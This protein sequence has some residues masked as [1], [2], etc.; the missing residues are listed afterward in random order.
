MS[1]P[2]GKITPVSTRSTPTMGR[3][4]VSSRMAVAVLCLI[5]FVDV[6]GVTVIVVALPSMLRDLD[7]AAAATGPVVTGY[8]MFFGGLLM[9]GARLGDRYGH[10]RVLVCGLAVFAVASLVGGVAGSVWLLVA[11]RCLQGCAAAVSVPT[12][13]R[14]LTWVTPSPPARRRAIAAWSAAGAAAG[15]SGFV[16]GGVATQTAGWRV[17]FLAGVPLAILLAV[18][19][20]RAVPETDDERADN[21]MDVAGAVLLTC[22]VM[23]LVLG[24]AA[25]EQPSSRPV[26]L[27][28]LVTGVALLPV[29]VRSQRRSTAALLPARAVRDRRLRVGAATAFVNTATTSSVVTLATLHLQEQAGLSPSAAGFNLVPVSLGV[30]AGAAAAAPGLRRFRPQSVLVMG[31]SGI[32]VG[33]AALLAVAGGTWLVPMAVGVLG[34]GLGL[35]SVASTTLGTDVPTGLQGTAS[36]ALNTMA[37]LGTALGVAALLLTASTV[38][39][40]DLA[41]TGAQVAWAAAAIAA[42][43]TALLVVLHDR[44]P[45]PRAAATR[46][47]S[48]RGERSPTTTGAEDPPV[49]QAHQSGR[50]G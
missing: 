21:H 2:P 26:G 48:R 14:L 27:L 39:R 50:M 11:G 12:A 28:A 41:V 6:L 10:R 36:G 46:R 32:L 47:G 25:V 5:Q 17:I 15:A 16:V 7:A 29:F 38:D 33:S 9:F 31:L 1:E 24:A 22:A 44:S 37:Q 49:G 42:L 3:P 45:P 19:V 4:T 13:L 23:A 35:S 30:V 20:L 40:L 18:L 8:A 43:V 34:I